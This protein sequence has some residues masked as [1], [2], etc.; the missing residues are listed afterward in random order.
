[1]PTVKN[2]QLGREMA[3]PYEAKYPARQFAFVFNTNRCIA[4]QTCTMACKSTWTFSR[5]QELMWWNNVET[6]PYGGYP[7][8]WDAKILSM[9]DRQ[10]PGGQVWDAQAEG[11]PYGVFRGKTIFEAAQTSARPEGAR[12]LGYLPTDEEWRFPN[13]Y[14]DVARETGTAEPAPRSYPQRAELPEHAT[15]FFY[16]QRLCNHC[17]YPACLAA[18][19]RKAIYK[20]KEDG[21]VLID[22]ERCRG[23]RRCVEACPYKKPMFRSTTRVSEKCIACYPRVTGQ[24]PLTEGQP[25]ETRCMTSCVGKIRI[26]GLVEIGEDGAWAREPQNPIYFLVHEAKVGLPLYPQ[27]GTSPNGYYIP[28]RWAPRPYLRQMF[29]PGVDHALEA[30]AAPSRELLAVLSLVRATQRI[31]HRFEIQEGPK[32]FEREINGRPWA[33]YNDTIIGF[34]KRGHEIVRTTVEEPIHVRE[35]RHANS[36]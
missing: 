7:Q 31:I 30:Y 36:I 10:N 8:N 17:T 29:G 18:C 25:M 24:D 13:I 34:D 9:L 22:Q 33:M 19:P 6:K 32:V 21:I 4:C 12:V 35:A 27:L 20:R 26:Q 1:M 16:L 23:Y 5:G 2:W 11:G 14:E 3:Y 28:P 15:W